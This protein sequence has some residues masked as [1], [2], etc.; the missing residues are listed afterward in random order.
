MSAARLLPLLFASACGVFGLDPVADGVPAD[1]AAPS[2]CTGLCVQGVNPDWGPLA[3]GT[4]VEVQGGGFGADAQVLFGSQ[5][6]ETTVLD[7]GRLVV[8]TPEARVEGAV[9]VTVQSGGQSDTLYDAFTYLDGGGGG[10]D[11]GGSGDNRGL[12]SGLVELSY[13]VVACPSCFGASSYLDYSVA[14]AFHAPVEGSWLSWMPA[15]GSCANDPSPTALS[16]QTQDVG[17]RVYLNS[18]AVSLALRRGG[19]GSAVIYQA[20]ALEQTDWVKNGAWDLELPELG[21]EVTGVAHGPQIFDTIT[22]TALLADG[23]QA[24]SATIN[25]SSAR[26]TWS[27]AGVAD[28]FVVRLD[29]YSSNGAS[30][31]GSVLCHASDSGSLTV[32]SGALSGYPSRALL[33]VWVYRLQIGGAERSDDGSTVESAASIGL[34]G[35]GTLQ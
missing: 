6:V 33:A 19:S 23:A 24:F 13:F 32:P 16:G 1:S 8:T 15:L 9:N 21:A 14:A 2:P 25:R 27:P 22:P 20:T 7:A 28:G 29:V 12:V 17:D 4:A 3:G 10:D 11:S 35:T 5:P 26:F 34:L 18:G 30:Y 31:L